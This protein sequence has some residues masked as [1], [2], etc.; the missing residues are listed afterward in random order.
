MMRRCWLAVWALWLAL[1]PIGAVWAYL[2][3]CAGQPT[4]ACC[5]ERSEATHARGACCSPNRQ[6]AACC[7]TSPSQGA[8]QHACCTQ[9]PC[10]EKGCAGC[11]LE[12]AKPAPTVASDNRPVLAWAHWVLD[13]P[14]LA[15]LARVEPLHGCFGLPA[16]RNHSP[17]QEPWTPRAPPLCCVC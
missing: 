17:P 2:C 15:G 9:Q 16:V 13:A 4:L 10:A 8:T 7:Q 14:V 1:A 6:A 3:V 11:S 5:A 12:R